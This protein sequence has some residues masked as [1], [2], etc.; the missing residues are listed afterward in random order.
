MFPGSSTQKT[1]RFGSTLRF[2]TS[3]A[4]RSLFRWKSCQAATRSCR[5][6]PRVHQ[7][8]SDG[9]RLIYTRNP[10]TP[11]YCARMTKEMEYKS[12]QD[13][14]AEKVVLGNCTLSESADPLRGLEPSQFYS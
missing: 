1:K 3:A 4:R 11:E 10:P 14:D 7:G 12:P 13:P 6:K 9:L 5:L 8:V 2:S